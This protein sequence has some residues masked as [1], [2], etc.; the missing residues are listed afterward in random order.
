M[1]KIFLKPVFFLFQPETIHRIVFNSLNFLF[2]IPG[3]LFLVKKSFSVTEQSIRKTVFGIDFPNPVGLAAG[4]DKNG[5]LTNEWSAFGFGFV[6]IGT[7]TPLPQ[8]GNPKPRM[9]RL[10]KDEAIINRMGF[11]NDGSVR[12]A[13]RLRKQNPKIIVGGN[14]GKNKITPNE[15]AINDYEKCFREL[16]D[17]VDYFVVN[18]S[19]PNTP[20]L[21]ELQDKEPLKRILN[22][23]QVIN[24]ELSLSRNGFQKA[25]SSSSSGNLKPVLLKIAPD[26]NNEQLDDIIEIVLSAKLAGIVATNTTVSRENLLTDHSAVQSIGAG[27]LSG[28]PVKKRS[29]EIIRYLKNKSQGKFEIIGV[30]GVHSAADALEKINAGAALVQIYTGFVYEGPG[31]VKKINRA[32][33]KLKAD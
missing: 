22:H 26:L 21:R 15:N 33:S 19:S 31:L 24:A 12:I 32:I 9:F 3:L 4:F 5:E 30:G 13:A 23:L 29:T 25:H 11:N 18:V 14:I 20:G 10:P 6:E 17:V 8:P 16:F 2:R 1:Y 27:G 28:K 7:V